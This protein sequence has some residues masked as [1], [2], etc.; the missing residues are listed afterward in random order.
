[1][2][3]EKWRRVTGRV[4]GGYCRGT[5]I[6][7]EL[8]GYCRGVGIWSCVIDHGFFRKNKRV[9]PS[10]ESLQKKICFQKCFSTKI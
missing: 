1:M 3:S 5:R 8:G 2:F 6:I 7:G 10:L 4:L 9:S